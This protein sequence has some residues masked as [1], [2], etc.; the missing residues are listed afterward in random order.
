MAGKQRHWT[1]HNDRFW[2]RMAIPATPWHT[3]GNKTQ[4]AAPLGGNLRNAN[5]KQPGAVARQEAKLEEARLALRGGMPLA[6]SPPPFP[7]I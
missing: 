2:A 1:Q 3:F 6:D 7:A 4:H 5:Q